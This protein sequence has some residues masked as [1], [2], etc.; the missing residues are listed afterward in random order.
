LTDRIAEKV[1]LLGLLTLAQ[2]WRIEDENAVQSGQ[3]SP[4]RRSIHSGAKR[5]TNLGDR[6]PTIQQGHQRCQIIGQANPVG[7]QSLMVRDE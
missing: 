6:M 2:A 4:K 3:D 5:S 7:C 1:G